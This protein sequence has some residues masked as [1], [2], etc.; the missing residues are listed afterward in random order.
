MKS[1][2]PP[3]TAAAA[4]SPR[5]TVNRNPLKALASEAGRVHRA[6]A[7]TFLGGVNAMAT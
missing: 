5:V 3:A 1:L 6:L 4:S 7:L 2:R